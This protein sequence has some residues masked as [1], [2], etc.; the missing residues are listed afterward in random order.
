MDII[1]HTHSTIRH[2]RKAALCTML[3]L[4]AS[5][6]TSASAQQGVPA[7][8][9]N[10]VSTVKAIYIQNINNP[11][12]WACV[13]VTAPTVHRNRHG[14]TTDGGFGTAPGL[15]YGSTY[16]ANAFSTPNCSNGTS[17]AGIYARGYTVNNTNEV[18]FT[19]ENN[20]IIIDEYPH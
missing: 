3:A 8:T 18:Y 9:V 17:M 20:T 15:L 11:N 6:A 1:M 5:A 2:F 19:I 12:G 7:Y 13:P 10:Y 16:S 4:G 14:T